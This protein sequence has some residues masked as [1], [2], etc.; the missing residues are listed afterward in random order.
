MKLAEINELLSSIDGVE[1]VPD[2]N[3]ISVS[4]ESLLQVADII[5]NKV[6]LDFDFLMCIT[7]LD[8]G[9]SNNFIIA[10]NFYSNKHKHYLELRV[11]LTDGQNVPS[12]SQ[13]WSTADWHERE[14]Y[15]MMGIKFSGHPNMKRI[16]LP[17]DWDGFPLRK[18][19][20]VSDY[21]RGVPV[22]KDKTYW[23]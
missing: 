2:L 7:A 23:E 5:K 15:D 19:F 10:Y 20:K 11:S 9:D 4:L 18:N 21:Y 13:V 3:Y 8:D 17:D 12:L 6:E 16:L 1:F 14:A 22:P